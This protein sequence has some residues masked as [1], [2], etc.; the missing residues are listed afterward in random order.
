VFKEMLAVA[1]GRPIV[2]A[3]H[4]LGTASALYLAAHHPEQRQI[5]GLLLHNP[6]PLV[7][8]LRGKYSRLTLG[9]S[10]FLVH[11]VPANLNTL[12]HARRTR[13]PAVFVT[14]GSDRMVPPELHQR[15]IEAYAGPH[16]VVDLPNA[17]HDIRFTRSERERYGQALDWLRQYVE[18]RVETRLLAS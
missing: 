10:R 9:W 4:S 14:G 7:E 16:Q 17:G 15:V 2:I 13:I 1:A 6:G 8:L 5:A 12:A 3:A 18:Q 11:Q